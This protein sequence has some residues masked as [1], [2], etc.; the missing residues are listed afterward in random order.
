METVLITGARGLLGSNLVNLVD[1]KK[2]NL[3]T[4]SST[5]LNI[6]NEKSVNDYFIKNKINLCIHCA[7]FKDVMDIENNI[8]ST[9]RAINTNVVGTI[10][11]LYSCINKNI[12]F[13]YISTDHVFDGNKG[14]YDIND[15]IN[16]LSKYAK[17]KGAAELIVRTYENS[18][19]IRTSFFD[20]YFPYD[21][22]FIDQWTTKDYIDVMAPLI[23]K[24]CFSDK[25]GIIHVASTK[26]TL[27]DIAVKRKE[28]VLKSSVKDISFKV[29]IDTSLK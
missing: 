3:L 13:I 12:K 17:T 26:Q 4:P 15:P 10:N 21:K 1:L 22:A 14:D 9:I 8:S 27:Y 19:I 18:I 7:A 23:I 28:N 24:E 20:K 16:P 6:S 25:K 11:L 5:I 2:Y 29:P